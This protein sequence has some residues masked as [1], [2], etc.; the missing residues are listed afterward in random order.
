MA[1]R[2]ELV[3][4]H[5]VA[6]IRFAGPARRARHRHGRL[7]RAVV[8][9]YG[10]SPPLGRAADLTRIIDDALRER[11]YLHAAITPRAEL[12][13]A[14]ER[15]T[16]VF[17]IDPGPRTHDRRHRDRRQPH[18][19]AGRAPRRGSVSRAGAPYQ[20][21]ALNARIEQYVDERRS[22]G[23]YEAKIL[24]AVQLADDDRVANL[25][26]TVTP[27]PH[28]R[29][30]FTG[31]PLPA[32][33]RAELVPIER[34]GSVDE[35]LLEDSSNRIEEYLR[36]QGYRD[37]TAP[38]TR[39]DANG[40]LVITF[41]VTRARS[42]RWRRSRSPATRRCRSPTSSR[43][44][45]CATA[46]RSRAPDST[47]TCSSSRTSTTA[48]ALRPRAAGRRS[49]SSRPTPPPAQVPVAVRIVITEGVRTIVDGVAFDGNQAM[50]EAA[51]RARLG[52]QPGAP[53]VPGQLAVDRDAIQLAYQNLGYPERDRRRTAGVQ[54]ERHA[55]GV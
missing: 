18:G 50:P 48:A 1:L 7:R 24:P 21:D 19:P 2:Y 39:E 38:H 33:R 9:R 29:V 47:P 41:T 51:L 3:P 55:R 45:G 11:G 40:E 43:R 26:L 22:R 15:A 4:I 23:Y 6:T 37:A 52:L 5:P 20:R 42:S 12:E 8:D 54:P 14:P 31:D 13:H 27:G 28:V 25:T 49:R 44:C 35:D 10:A 30:V 34:E 17:T 36:A 46:S 53:F 32:D 16:L